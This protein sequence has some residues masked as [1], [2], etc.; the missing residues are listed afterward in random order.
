MRRFALP[1]AAALAVTVVGA[2]PALAG[3]G[4]PEIGSLQAGPFAATLH[5]D[6][7]TMVSGRNTLTVGIL[8]LPDHFAVSLSLTGPQGQHL[9]VPL[10]PV[11]VLDA[12]D[13]H[14]S[15]SDSHG[16]GDHQAAPELG[17]HGT[18][19]QIPEGADHRAQLETAEHG[20][21]GHGEQTSD[22]QAEPS[23]GG[24]EASMEG[25]HG[26]PPAP[27]AAVDFRVV[28]AV[29]DDKESGM[30]HGAPA[31]A[32]THE[33]D[34]ERTR[35]LAGKPF[36]ARGAVTVPTTGNWTARLVIYEDGRQAFAAQA[37]VE[38][39]EG[40]PSKLYLAGAGALMGGFLLY[41]VAR[42]RAASPNSR[43]GR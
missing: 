30:D 5:N 10:R 7:P 34:H 13:E 21:G 35:G 14:G 16:S 28:S 39:M 36:L 18:G 12:G 23:A 2:M 38:V 26:A 3:G 11:L 19:A 24:H 20:A 42:R 33:Q 43:K 40:G 31:T 25:M 9:D 22:H 6:S 15:E 4:L 41:G 27:R 8:S 32:L 1:F 37:P 29:V 17:G